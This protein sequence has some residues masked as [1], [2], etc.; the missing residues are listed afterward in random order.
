[1]ARDLETEPIQTPIQTEPGGRP[2]TPPERARRQPEAPPAEPPARAKR[3]FFREHPIALLAG[4]VLLVILAIGGILLWNYWS[5]YESTDDAQM[6]GHIYPIS[7]RVSGR[8]IAVNVEIN[9]PVKAGQVV[10]QLDPT[11]YKIGLEKSKADFAQAQADAQAASTQVPIIAQNVSS[12]TAGAGASV[13][14]AQAAVAAAQEQYNA[15]VARIREAQ[16]NFEKAQKDVERFRPLVAK[17]EISQQ[18]FD[19]AVATAGA[20]GAMV[21]T[22]RANADALARQVTQARARVAQVEAEETA[23]RSAP[24]QIQAQRARAASSQANANAELTNVHQAELNVQYTTITAPVDGIVGRRAVEVGQQVQAGQELMAVVPLND[25]WVTA[26]YK[27]TQLK[28]I[29]VGQRVTVHV[30]A[31]QSD[32]KAHVDS[33]PGATGSRFSMLPPENATGNFVKVVQRLPVKIVFDSGQDTH[34][35]RPGMS[36]ETKVWI[37]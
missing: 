15:A 17:Q 22:A 10:I 6:D 11:D 31:V 30:D 2:A 33:F 8:V 29:R 5:S 1:M 14:E 37:K 32:L 13:R 20:M 35:L 26:D 24:Q 27:E 34:L 21:D 3:S 23:T 7:P 16:A 36:V 12:Q 25:L 9:Q 19:Q 28:N 18:Q 4:A